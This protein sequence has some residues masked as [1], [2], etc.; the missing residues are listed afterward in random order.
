MGEVERIDQR[1]G[2]LVSFNLFGMSIIYVPM[3]GSLCAI[4]EC[5]LKRKGKEG[6]KPLGDFVSSEGSVSTH[7][8]VDLPVPKVV[9]SGDVSANDLVRIRRICQAVSGLAGKERNANLK[10]FM[11]ENVPSIPLFDYL[12]RLVKY[13]NVYNKGV[14]YELDGAKVSLG[15]VYLHI[16]LCY[17]DR[18]PNALMGI[19]VYNVHRVFAVLIFIAHKY[20]AEEKHKFSVHKIV[21]ITGIPQES[22]IAMETKMVVDILKF[23]LYIVKE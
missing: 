6:E 17:L 10:E 7:D 22:L 19:N 11:G 15:L 13:V 4:K 8:T 23:D 16:A 2:T 20:C 9:S 18:I 14:V 12:S 21:D 5:I 1:E 3:E